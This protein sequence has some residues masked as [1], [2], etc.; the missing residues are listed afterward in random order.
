MSAQYQPSQ[1][2]IAQQQSD[3]VG[4][5]QIERRLKQEEAE[6]NT[7]VAQS[8]NAD[9]QLSVPQSSGADFTPQLSTPRANGPI[10]DTYSP[11]GDPAHPAQHRAPSLRQ[12]EA[13]ATP[14]FDETSSRAG[15]DRA[16]DTSPD[17]LRAA[18]AER[19]NRLMAAAGEAGD[20][21][22]AKAQQAARPRAAVDDDVF[23]RDDGSETARN[24][25]SARASANP[26]QAAA[27]ARLQRLSAAAGQAPGSPVTGSIRDFLPPALSAALQRHD[28]I[29]SMEGPAPSKKR[30]A[31]ADP[32][33]HYDVDSRTIFDARPHRPHPAH[34][35][36]A[37]KTFG[38]EQ[39]RM[40]S[41]LEKAAGLKVGPGRP[42]LLREETAPGKGGEMQL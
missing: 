5:E 18:A 35:D 29:R 37:A 42:A 36:A 11:D 6:D 8:G 4:E 15:A 1:D 19:I 32:Y 41:R 38:Q 25:R 28:L 23:A 9:N 21:S 39:Q 26:L 30:A 31:A 10:G 33:G 3:L 2:E 7:I 13:P 24:Q 34:T 20:N 12:D 16:E 22:D 27:A 14:E 40:I 17:T